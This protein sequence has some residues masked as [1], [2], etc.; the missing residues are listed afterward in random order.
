MPER[1]CIRNATRP[2]RHA[3]RD[4]VVLARRTGFDCC[5]R[6]ACSPHH[7]DGG[8]RV[9]IKPWHEQP[10]LAERHVLSAL[11]LLIR[12]HLHTQSVPA[13]DKY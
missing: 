13:A 5:L 11:A 7:V 2:A 1:L 12:V 6:D 8:R 3:T 4:T 10:S 9:T